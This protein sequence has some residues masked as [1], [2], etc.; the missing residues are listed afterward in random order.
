M[1]DTFD[2]VVRNILAPIDNATAVT[3]NDSTDLSY[4]TRGFMVGGSGAVNV[5]MAGP[6]GDTTVLFTGCIAGQ[7]YPFRV[8]RIRS[9]STTATDIRALW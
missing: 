3:P 6:D 7:V 4:V 1:T 9:T 5:D 2:D 8:R